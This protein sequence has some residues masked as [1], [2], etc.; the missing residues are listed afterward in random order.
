VRF[1]SCPP[2]LG[3]PHQKTSKTCNPFALTFPLKTVTIHFTRKS[4]RLDQLDLMRPMT[5]RWMSLIAAILFLAGVGVYSYQRGND[6]TA[7]RAAMLALMP[8]DACAVLYADVG[9]LR[10]S[11]FAA[12]LYNWAPQPQIDPEY[13]RFL[14]DTGFDYER[15]LD[16]VALAFLKRG[17][18]TTVLAVADGRFE[19]KRIEA[20]A[21]Q[22]GLRSHRD[23]RDFFQLPVSGSAQKVSLVFLRPD[24]IALTNDADF[25]ASL[26]QSPSREDVRE[27]RERFERLA[28]SPVF[29]VLRQEAFAGSALAAHAPG[30]L[31]SP[32]LASLLNQLLWITL[33]G[34]PEGESLRLVAEGESGDDRT[35][36]QLD[37]LL[38]GILLLAQAGLNGPDT[39]RQL[40]PPTREAYLEILRGADVSRIDRGETKSVR[41]IIQ[42][43]PKLLDTAKTLV[44]FPPTSTPSSAPN[45]ASTGIGAPAVQPKRHRKQVR[46]AGH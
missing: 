33:A 29:A 27:W 44:P 19:Q 35:A 1:A 39:R 43:T 18:N 22:S 38:N 11:V 10:S 36:R 5:K 42:V 41:V 26:N 8:A 46:E 7:T 31:Q 13:A 28:G 32:Q 37:D 25:S 6:A 20:Y 40:A 21:S 34:K 4:L 9:E 24:R 23:G 14:H 15:D 30:G 17:S 16:R 12:E 3:F 45:S 2:H